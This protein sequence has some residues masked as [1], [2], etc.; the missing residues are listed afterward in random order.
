MC[1]CVYMHT[2]AYCIRIYLPSPKISFQFSWFD[3][4]MSFYIFN[5]SFMP[6][7]FFFQALWKYTHLIFLLL[8]WLFWLSQL[9]LLHFLILTSTCPL[10]SYLFFFMSFVYIHF[11]H[12]HPIPYCLATQTCFWH[13][14]FFYWCLALSWTPI[15]STWLSKNLNLHM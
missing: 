14:N 15:I 7:V 11:L 1:I 13:T 4:S 5:Y 12:T 10:G 9:N 8:Y 2:C 3:F 6:E